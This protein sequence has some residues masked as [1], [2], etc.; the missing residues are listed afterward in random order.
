MRKGIAAVVVAGV[1]FS[2]WLVHARYKARL[3]ESRTAQAKRDAA[4]QL[5]L[6][7]FHRDVQLR[8]PRSGVKKYL[9]LKQVQ[10][11]EWEWNIRTK[12]GEDPGDGFTC[13]RWG[14]YID[15]HF[16]PVQVQTEPSEFDHL[17]GIAITKI[18]HCL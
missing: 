5:V 11:S 15:F 16:E 4:Y 13:D 1:L 9:D 8:M 3:A 2:G 7:Q 10:Y 17:S 14:V 6:A 18:G 12:I